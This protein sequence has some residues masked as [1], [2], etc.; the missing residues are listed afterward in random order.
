M[1]GL[2]GL[3]VTRRV[4]DLELTLGVA[5]VSIVALTAHALPERILACHLAGMDEVLTKPI[6]P[7]VFRRLIAGP[8]RL[9]DAG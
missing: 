4:R 3:A 1:P 5:P 7:A 2:D 8:D 9:A 6:D